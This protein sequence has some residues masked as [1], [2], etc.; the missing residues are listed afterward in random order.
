M[1]LNKIRS[2][3]SKKY[4]KSFE[5]NVKD[6]LCQQIKTEQTKRNG[7]KVFRREF[8]LFQESGGVYMYNYIYA[9]EILREGVVAKKK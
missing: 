1:L 2:G 3:T 6:T 7:K 8:V 4:K 5:R 9:V